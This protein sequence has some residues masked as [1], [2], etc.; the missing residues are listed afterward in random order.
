[1]DRNSA[2][3]RYPIRI[4]PA[5]REHARGN[6]ERPPKLAAIRGVSD[7]AIVAER[8]SVENGSFCWLMSN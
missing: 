6:H 3:F 8:R 4:P 1:L 7:E 2:E 5:L